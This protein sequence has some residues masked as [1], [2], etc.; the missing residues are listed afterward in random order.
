LTRNSAD[1]SPPGQPLLVV[2]NA[3]LCLCVLGGCYGH[4]FITLPLFVLG[5]ALPCFFSCFLQFLFGVFLR[6]PTRLHVREQE[7]CG[8]IESRKDGALI[9]PA[10]W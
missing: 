7:A 9:G 6:K 8:L 1:R 4:A 2:G 5:L 3:L 10:I